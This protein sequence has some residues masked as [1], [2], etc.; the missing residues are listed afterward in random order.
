MFSKMKM[1]FFDIVNV[2]LLF[3]HLTVLQFVFAK[4]CLKNNAFASF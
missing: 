1:P 2:A 4:E 3:V